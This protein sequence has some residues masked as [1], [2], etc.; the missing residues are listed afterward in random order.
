MDLQFSPT[1]LGYFKKH[2]GAEATRGRDSVKRDA[3]CGQEREQS[4]RGEGKEGSTGCVDTTGS[5]GTRSHRNQQWRSLCGSPLTPATASARWSEPPLRSPGVDRWFAHAQRMGAGD[6]LAGATVSHV[7][8]ETTRQPGSR[9]KDV[10]VQ[11]GEGPGR[12]SG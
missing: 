12:A 1:L 4:G 10:S 11:D 9:G 7:A 3:V 5:A 2:T 6:P 8:L